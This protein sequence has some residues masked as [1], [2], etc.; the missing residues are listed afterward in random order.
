MG[1]ADAGV[2]C[3]SLDDGAAWPKEARLLSMFDDEERSAVFYRAAGVLELGF[4]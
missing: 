4:S 1:K 2:S 3:G